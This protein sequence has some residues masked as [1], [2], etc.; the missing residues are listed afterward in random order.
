MR[1]LAHGCVLALCCILGANSPLLAADD[2]VIG[3]VDKCAAEARIPTPDNS[4]GKRWAELNV[5]TAVLVCRAAFD[6]APDD[7]EVMAN[8]GR[9][10]LRAGDHRRAQELL[11]AAADRSSQAKFSLA[12]SNLS[13]KMLATHDWVEGAEN[14][15]A[16]DKRA[17]NRRSDASDGQGNGAQSGD[18]DGSG[19]D[20]ETAGRPAD[21]EGTRSLEEFVRLITSGAQT[22]Y[23]PAQIALGKYRIG[24]LGMIERDELDIVGAAAVFRRAADAG[25]AE[26]KYWL[27]YSYRFAMGAP[28]DP[29]ES[30]RLYVEAAEAGFVPALT[31]VGNLYHDGFGF[32]QD[33]AAGDQWFRRAASAGDSYGQFLL[34]RSLEAQEGDPSVIS[35]LLERAAQSGNAAAQAMLADR[36]AS[37]D[38]AQATKLYEH[39]A[40]QGHLLAGMLGLGAPTGTKFALRITGSTQNLMNYSKILPSLPVDPNLVFYGYRASQ[41][42]IDAYMERTYD[43]IGQ[44][45]VSIAKKIIAKRTVQGFNTSMSL[46][47]AK[48]ALLTSANDGDVEAATILAYPPESLSEKIVSKQERK[49]WQAWLEKLEPNKRRDLVQA[50]TEGH[51]KQ[52]NFSLVLSGLEKPSAL[53]GGAQ[54][55]TQLETLSKFHLYSLAI[56]RAINLVE[57]PEFRALPLGERLEFVNSIASG[58]QSTCAWRASVSAFVQQA[59][60]LKEATECNEQSA[61]FRATPQQLEKLFES[62][63]TRA[64][65]QLAYLHRAGELGTADDAKAA[66]WLQTAIDRCPAFED[67]LEQPETAADHH[68]S[69][70]NLP[71]RCDTDTKI[72]KIM[73][74]ILYE[75]GEGVERNPER[76]FELYREGALGG[77][78]VSSQ[79]NCP[80]CV[81]LGVADIDPV[82]A[83][84]AV[85]LYMSGVAGKLSNDEVVRLLSAASRY[86]EPTA[87]RM[88]GIIYLKGQLVP[89]DDAEGARWLLKAAL[90]GDADAQF[91]LGMLYEKGIGVGRDSDRA[92]RWYAV[93]AEGG[94]TSTNLTI[95]PAPL[96]SAGKSVDLDATIAS[97][98]STLDRY[99]QEADFDPRLKLDLEDV[100]SYHRLLNNADGMIATRLKAL[101]VNDAMLTKKHGTMEN[102]FALLSSSCQWGRASLEA[103]KSQRP[104][105]ALYF[106]KVSV[107]KLQQARGF[108][109]Q[110][111]RNL[112]ECFLEV[113]QDRYRWLADLLM[114]MGRYPEAEQVIAML[115]D[116]EF[117]EFTRNGDAG[118]SGDGLAFSAL[119]KASY[120]SYSGLSSELLKA[121]QAAAQLSAKPR[122]ERTPEEVE[123]NRA[124]QRIIGE[125]R[126]SFRAHFDALRSEISALRSA[127]GSGEG[128]GGWESGAGESVSLTL[129]EGGFADNAA[130]LYA[131]VTPTRIHWLVST[132][133]LQ[134]A[135]PIEVKQEDLQRAIGQYR[136]ALVARDPT[137]NA[138]AKSL[139]SLIFAPVDAELKQLG[140]TTVLLSLDGSLR[141]VPFAA[142][143]DG[144]DW[145]ARRYAFSAFRGTERL[146]AKQ[147]DH[148]D[149]VIAGF[150]VTREA[151][152][153]SGNRF[154]PLPAVAGELAAIV[155]GVGGAATG[156]IQLD[157]KFDRRSLENA[158]LDG[159]PVLHIAT[160][161]KLAPDA[162]DSVLLLG[163]NDELA[164][165]N[166]RRDGVFTFKDVSLLA[167]SACQTAVSTEANS[168]S[169]FDSMGE[170]AQKAG[171]ASVLASLWS[172]N[173][174]STASLMRAFY[175]NM[176][177]GKMGKADALRHVQLAFLDRKI[178][179]TT[180]S[181]GLRATSLGR[182]GGLAEAA[183]EWDHPFYWAPFVLMGNIN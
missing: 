182:D 136:A 10:L 20:D 94:V 137:I 89:R 36:I 72:A 32:P 109:N 58:L 117:Q 77:R 121:Y 112:R 154:P 183:T 160:H 107:N 41:Q 80:E 43:V 142:L 178:A 37:Q 75:R 119:E 30:A 143:N 173:D 11:A 104:E 6:A 28:K 138:K 116:F 102:Y 168:G 40:E 108:L 115:K 134:R 163:N 5:E 34:A 61:I 35:D 85:R 54:E 144:Q 68:R 38:P 141:Y 153:K 52:L 95:E 7:P 129:S 17:A 18:G 83:A 99:I 12:M 1:H 2:A 165:S 123:K 158:I 65:V 24:A 33:R 9:T 155:G 42:E 127:S 25:S 151:T 56:D 162:D 180:S 97:L 19:G 172:V 16:Q 114:E 87:Q 118:R 51:G 124:A 128:A 130:A 15:S 69:F 50:I 64:G 140:I 167:L 3:L 96:Q 59:R 132:K 150:G 27:A 45:Q 49:K 53:S 81:L 103:Y 71:S 169:E 57:S 4:V 139:Y 111:D 125:A 82:A 177:E 149:W 122:A 76:A 31:A 106:A 161:F 159:V 22:S 48:A 179:R 88:L 46:A 29:R 98:E 90:G 181:A 26:A 14:A 166:F 78:R 86:E 133:T 120:A 157:E 8:L 170:V 100:A 146:A 164:L 84:G 131:V 47:E 13:M 147:V 62:G 135:I 21:V 66:H 91:E 176:I 23:V 92:K 175:T 74:A 73:L 93:A 152:T 60:M 156:S 39:A 110:L 101:A 174:G 126:S 105:V 148:S 55:R 70:R 79:T 145:L 113:H 171:A 63:F 67:P 44:M